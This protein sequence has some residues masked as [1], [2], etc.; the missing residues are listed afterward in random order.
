MIALLSAREMGSKIPEDSSPVTRVREH[1]RMAR[2]HRDAHPRDPRVRRDLQ[3]LMKRLQ[4][5]KQR[6]GFE[7]IEVSDPA[8]ETAHSLKIVGNEM[9]A[10]IPERRGA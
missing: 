7:R 9:L 5:L 8:R 1:L 10:L 6:P 2:S 3:T 4:S